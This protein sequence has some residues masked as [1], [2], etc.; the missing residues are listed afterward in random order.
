MI[1]ILLSLGAAF[2]FGS[3]LLILKTLVRKGI[4]NFMVAFTFLYFCALF[5]LVCVFSLLFFYIEIFDDQQP[6][7]YLS[8]IL[9]GIF[10]ST[11]MV[12]LNI[13][14]SYGN[15]GLCNAITNS[16]VILVTIFNMVVFNQQLNVVQIVGIGLAL[17]GVVML[18]IPGRICCAK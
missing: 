9:S 8:S 10:L 4:D 11:G 18:S 1:T 15:P 16:Q 13:A 5:G 17:L 14:S 3:Q 12:C 7:H 6:Q 2:S